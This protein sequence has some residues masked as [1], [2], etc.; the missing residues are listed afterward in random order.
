MENTPITTKE[1]VSVA[2]PNCATLCELRDDEIEPSNP[3]DLRPPMPIY[4][5]DCAC[6][7]RTDF[8]EIELADA[9]VMAWCPC[10]VPTWQLTGVC[11]D[12]QCNEREAGKAVAA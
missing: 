7:T 4:W 6:G 5:I 11:W 2:C 3:F 10:G 9:D 1:D 12:C 8:D